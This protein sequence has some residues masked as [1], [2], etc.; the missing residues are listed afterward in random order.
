AWEIDGLRNAVGPLHAQHVGFEMRPQ[1]KVCDAIGGDARLVD[2]TGAQL[3]PGTDSKC[4]ILATAIA[5]S[6]EL[7]VDRQIT[8]SHLVAQQPRS[9]SAVDQPE[10]L[11][12]IIIDV[13]HR[14]RRSPSRAHGWWYHSGLIDKLSGT[15]VAEQEYVRRGFAGRTRC[16]GH[17]QI[18]PAVIVVVDE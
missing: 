11:V 9:A 16:S 17:D 1:S 14:N 7:D 13:R 3:Q 5:Q 12:A 4:V 8:V 18:D 6:L 10:I 2:R 15:V